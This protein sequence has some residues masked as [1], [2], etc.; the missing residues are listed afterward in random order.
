MNWIY[1]SPHL[2]DAALSSG[3][4]IWEQTR[5]GDSVSIWTICAG[6]PPPGE[7]SSFARKLHDRWETGADAVAERRQEDIASCKQLNASY[8]HFNVS[9]CIYRRI[10]QVLEVNNTIPREG[11]EQS[12]FPYN[13]EEALFGQLHPA[14]EK[15][16]KELSLE[17]IHAIPQ[18]TNIIAPLAIGNHVDHQL[19]RAAAESTGRELWYYQDYPYILGWLNELDELE[20]A[21][22]KKDLYTISQDGFQAWTKS[23][24]AHQSQI[25]TFWEN[26]EGMRESIDYY[27]GQFGG[28]NLWK[29]P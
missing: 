3:G 7:F 16:V 4:L 10:D 25:S 2:D 27:L 26:L 14:E 5:S 24:A 11:F 29:K 21:G 23:I 20:L 28:I 6:N 18:N 8:R 9:D 19:T 1:L 17:L 12:I 22:W 13:S 15:L